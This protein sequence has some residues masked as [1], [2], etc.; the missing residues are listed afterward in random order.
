MSLENKW[1]NRDVGGG[2]G[3]A[4]GQESGGDR[5]RSE[6]KGD[7][8]IM[9]RSRI[10]SGKAFKTDNKKGDKLYIVSPPT[11]TPLFKGGILYITKNSK[12]Y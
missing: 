8:N 11:P 9:I 4:S 1:F 12:Y 6:S 10:G 5:F 7:G 3:G 2:G